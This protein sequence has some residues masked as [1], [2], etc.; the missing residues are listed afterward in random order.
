M[1]VSVKPVKKKGISYFSVKV[2]EG[3]DF[4]IGVVN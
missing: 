2:I 3:V 1:L 4:Y